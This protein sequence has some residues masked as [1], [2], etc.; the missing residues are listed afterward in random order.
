[1]TPI[2]PANT[3][4]VTGGTGFLGAYI[5]KHLVEGG[6]HVRALRRT[7]SK[8]PSFIPAAVLEKVAWVNGDVLD[9]V[10]LEESMQGVDAGDSFS[11]QS[12]V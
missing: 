8:L 11:C 1:M 2:H 4:L 7:G 6:Y 10:S 5:I 3:I 12:F 9:I